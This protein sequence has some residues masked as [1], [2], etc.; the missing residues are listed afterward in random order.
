MRRTGKKY[1]RRARE[2]GMGC[3]V[4]FSVVEGGGGHFTPLKM[5][6]P[7]LSFSQFSLE[8]FLII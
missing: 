2:N 8:F 7:P 6:W 1:I 5:F 4:F 3:M